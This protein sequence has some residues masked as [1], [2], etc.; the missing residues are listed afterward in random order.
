MF[1]IRKMLKR[2]G[3][4]KVMVIMLTSLT[5]V[6]TTIMPITAAPAGVQTGVVH[7]PP[8]YFVPGYRLQLDATVSDPAGVSVVRC[9]FKAAGEADYVFVPMTRTGGTSKG[10]LYSGV[11]P[12]PTPGTKQVKYLFLVVN[13]NN[14]VIKTQT[15]TIIGENK[16]KAPA[17]QHGA[18]KD[19]IQVSME[20][21][22][23]PSEL[24]GFTD[25]IAINKIESGARFGL[26][27]GGLYYLTKDKKSHTTGRAASSNYA[28]EITAKAAGYSTK[29]LVGAGVL[30]A[31]VVGG[32]IALSG[33]GGGGGSSDK[34][35]P[36]T[37]SPTPPPSPTPTPTPTPTPPPTPT[38]TPTANPLDET[39]I[40]GDWNFSGYRYDLVSRSGTM[41]FSSGGTMS[42]MVVN[43]DGYGNEAGTGSWF[44]S[45]NSLSLY[46]ISISPWIGSAT[47]DDQAFVLDTTGGSGHGVYNF[48]R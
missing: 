18:G 4:G 26:V 15:F 3:P 20:L 12:A 2:N 30:G 17:W 28:G 11:L 44:L 29:F 41:T 42:Y 38:P 36:P 39:T 10:V 25:N 5:L 32:A 8:A 6:F 1:G 37:P 45:G 7:G 22:K 47:G 31:A 16:D 27:A 43:G 23:V 14:N 48:S 35:D 46:F 24:R 34:K 33:G 19:Q 13:N 9:Y 21:D 40:L